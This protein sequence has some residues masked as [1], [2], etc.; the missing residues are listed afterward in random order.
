MKLT[1]SK[2]K[3]IIQE[4][5]KTLNEL[6]DWEPQSKYNVGDLVEVEISDDGY[7]KSIEKLG[8]ENEF[9][10]THGTYTAEKFLAKIILVSKREYED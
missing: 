4:E 3:Q 1:K 5:L 9:T 2:L 8:S 6:E 7:D 10:P